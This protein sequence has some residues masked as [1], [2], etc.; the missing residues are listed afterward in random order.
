MIGDM[1]GMA[2]IFDRE[3]LLILEFLCPIP[4]AY[5]VGREVCLLM[6]SR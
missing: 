1:Q 5:G 3:D 6:N 2:Y 4:R